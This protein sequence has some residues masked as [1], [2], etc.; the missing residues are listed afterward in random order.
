MDK[1]QQM[2]LRSIIETSAKQNDEPVEI[3][4]SQRAKRPIIEFE[5]N[6]KLNNFGTFNKKDVDLI[7]DFTTDVFST[8]E[9]SIGYN[10]DGVDI[11]K[12]MRI[13]FTADP[14]LLVNGRIFEVDI[15]KFA[16]NQS[17]NN[18]ITLKEVRDGITPKITKLYLH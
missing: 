6:L 1:I 4:Q 2:V 8:I 18:Q 17:T 16:N 13:L 10:I 14:D 3:D 11:V 9:G 15:I 5:S 12:G 7:D